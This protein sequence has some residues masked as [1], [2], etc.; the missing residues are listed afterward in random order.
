MANKSKKHL[1]KG[2]KEK[3]DILGTGL[4]NMTYKDMKRRAVALG[5]PFPEACA[6]DYN[7]L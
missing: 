5:M 4:G 1:I 2:S 6:A 7:G 3:L